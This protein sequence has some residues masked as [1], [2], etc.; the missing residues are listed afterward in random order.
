MLV[1]FSINHLYLLNE[2]LYR[3]EGRK[4]WWWW[5]HVCFMPLYECSYRVPLYWVNQSSVVWR[6]TC[7]R[8]VMWKNYTFILI[9][10]S[11]FSV[12]E[13]A[14]YAALSGNLSQ[15]CRYWMVLVKALLNLSCGC[16]LVCTALDVSDVT[17]LTLVI[18]LDD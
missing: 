1:T 13:R 3:M 14:I 6:I 8:G 17:M 9:Y 2:K 7:C 10:Q 4:K 18:Y 11:K 16:I 12:Y 5:V 15:V